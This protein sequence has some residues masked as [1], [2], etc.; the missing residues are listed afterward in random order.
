MYLEEAF[1]RANGGSDRVTPA[2]FPR[3]EFRAEKIIDRHTFGRVRVMQ[4]VPEAVKRLMVEL[5]NLEQSRSEAVET[6]A[7]KS[8]SNDGYSESYEVITPEQAEQMELS[9]ICT[10]LSGETNDR[11]VPLL[12]LG[13]EEWRC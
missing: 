9:L 2:A 6:P 5:V 3:L 7:V 4:N 10:Y 1:F 13:S 8:F 11:G 12:Y